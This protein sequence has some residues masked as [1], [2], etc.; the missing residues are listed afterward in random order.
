[1]H[2]LQL[3]G[4]VF[5]INYSDFYKTV[6]VPC[7][8]FFIG[9]NTPAGFIYADCDLLNEANL[10]KLYIIKGGPGTGKSTLMKKCRAHFEELGYTVCSYYC[11]SDPNSLDAI[12]IEKG[13]TR[14]A[15]ADGTAPHAIDGRLPGAVSKIIDLGALWDGNALE[16]QMKNIAVECAAKA[17]AFDTAKKYLAS[18]KEIKDVLSHSSAKGFNTEKAKKFIA[19]LLSSIPKQKTEAVKHKVITEAISMNGALRL[20]TFDKAETLVGIEDFG[21]ISPLFLELL[22]N[23]VEKSGRSLVVSRSPLGE[24]AEIYLPQPNIAFVPARE[25]TEYDK[26]IRLSRFAQREY[27]SSCSAKRRFNN[28]CFIEMLD[29]ALSALEDAKMHH[30]A[31]EEIYAKAMDFSGM[32]YIYNN[33]ITSIEKKLLG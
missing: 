21:G 8:S 3:K 16:N 24:I 7:N 32:E 10:D 20:S 33:L 4:G 23:A 29:G 1:M 22:E 28:R 26:Y 25:G 31:L 17:L 13:S 27:F 12:I 9:A 14:I 19:R 11:S 2:I 5:L 18:A 6:D 15:I 30:F